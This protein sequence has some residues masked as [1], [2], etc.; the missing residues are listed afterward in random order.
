[1]SRKLLVILLVFGLLVG[2]LAIAPG[3]KGNTQHNYSPA[4]GNVIYGEGAYHHVRFISCG[5][6][7]W[8]WNGYY[9]NYA[10]EAGYSFGGG[11][12]TI[13]TFTMDGTDYKD[14]SG[15]QAS[16]VYTGT[17]IIG[18][19]VQFYCPSGSHTFSWYWR[20]E[21]IFTNQD[22][23]YIGSVTYD[24]TAYGYGYDG[25][26]DYGPGVWPLESGPLVV[27]I[28]S[29]PTSVDLVNGGTWHAAAT[30]GATPYTYYWDWSPLG[31]VYHY[32]TPFDPVGPT[33]SDTYSHTWPTAGTYV[34]ECMVQD[35]DGTWADATY[36]VS[37][38]SVIGSYHAIFTRYG[39]KGQYLNV[40][41]DDTEGNPVTISSTAG[42]QYGLYEA[43]GAFGW[44]AADSEAAQLVTYTWRWVMGYTVTPPGLSLPPPADFWIETSIHLAVPN[45]DLQVTH[46]FTSLSETL[47]PW[48]GPGGDPQVPETP[49]S[50]TST[51][52]DWLQPV[53]DMF[54]RLLRF[55]FVPSASDFSA[56][57]ASGWILIASPVPSITPQYTIPFPNPQ[58]L[59]AETGDSVNIDFSGIQSYSGYAVYKAIVQAILDALLLFLVISL[60]A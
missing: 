41:V 28:D 16:A 26:S 20:T 22:V 23:V 7:A 25:G 42:T 4:Y 5:G 44:F 24:Y 31:G 10:P 33:G 11:E 2:N 32:N 54:V 30:G 27:T 45:I 17:T 51:L 40:Q 34:L 15:F 6:P 58:H 1:M 43:G 13:S 57:L 9:I 52:P 3:V 53:Y 46:H 50:E 19:M 60:V 21:N 47:D 39:D 8:G 35:A 18:A 55:L 56:Q 48:Y 14:G 37:A 49:P 59:L 29:G 12:N 38:A 36:Q